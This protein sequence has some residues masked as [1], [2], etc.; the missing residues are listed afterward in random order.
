MSDETISIERA[1]LELMDG[2]SESAQMWLDT[3]S[4]ILRGLTPRVYAENYG[5][6]DVVDL[7]GRIRNGVFS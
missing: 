2:D 5:P 6:D 4:K 7:V 1:A 3:P